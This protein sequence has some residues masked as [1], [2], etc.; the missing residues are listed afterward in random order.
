MNKDSGQND[1]GGNLATQLW[2]CQK[3]ID[4]VGNS[5]KASFNLNLCG[6]V[7]QD[8]CYKFMTLAIDDDVKDA[9][10][11][12]KLPPKATMDAVNEVKTT[13]N[14]KKLDELLKSFPDLKYY[15]GKLLEATNGDAKKAIELTPSVGKLGVT[16]PFNYWVPS[17]TE[18]LL[19][20]ACQAYIS[21]LIVN[22]DRIQPTSK[23]GIKCN[24]V[25]FLEKCDEAKNEY[26]IWT[27]GSTMK[28]TKETI[29]GGPLPEK[30]DTQSFYN[31]G[32]ICGA[33]NTKHITWVNTEKLEALSLV[34]KSFSAHWS[35]LSF[36]PIVG[37]SA[38]IGFSLLL[39]AFARYRRAKQ[40]EE[41]QSILSDGS[42]EDALGVSGNA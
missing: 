26:T 11:A 42:S 13:G 27:W 17:F 16:Y 5:C 2:E 39:A 9:A 8:L 37:I 25:V 33:V 34:Q 32:V 30:I 38:T 7:P 20:E 29:L 35:T 19:K 21:L 3:F 10:F 41:Q 22:A 15:Y 23:P 14:S 4:P 1:Q 40:L 28:L 24:H 6:K 18:N 31:T 36:F 12:A